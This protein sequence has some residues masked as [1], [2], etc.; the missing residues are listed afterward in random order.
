MDKR[1]SISAEVIFKSKIGK[2]MIKSDSPITSKNIHEFEPPAENIK[3]V[4]KKLKELGFEVFQ[5]GITV[6]LVGDPLLFEKIF[7]TKLSIRRNKK[8]IMSV[9]PDKEPVCPQE[10]SDVIEKIVFPPAPIFFNN[11]KPINQ[12]KV[13]NP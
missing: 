7:K 2:S 6:T 8:N 12:S 10:F 9:N 3:I 4:M 13:T 11:I 1:N 5:N